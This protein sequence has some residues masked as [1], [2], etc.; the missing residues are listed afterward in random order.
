MP[1]SP[2]PYVK[3]NWYCT[4]IGGIQHQKLCPAEQGM[5]RAVECLAS[6]MA[7]R[8]QAR[9]SGMSLPSPGP[10]IASPMSEASS[11]IV[12]SVLDDF[13]EFKE[14]ENPGPT[15][16][17]YKE[18]LKPI[19]T[20]FGTRPIATISTSD[21]TKYKGWLRRD[22][23]WKRGKNSV[24]RKGVG[25]TTVNHHL[26]AAKMFFSWAY[27][28]SRRHKYG[29][30]MNVFEEIGYLTEIPRDRLITEEEFKH[31]LEN[32]TDGNVAGGREDYQDMLRVLRRT[33]MRPQE[34][35]YL[36]WGYIH[37]SEHRIVF[38]ANRVKTKNRREVVLLDEVIVL[39]RNRFERL[40]KDLG[41]KPPSSNYVFAL[42]GKGVDGQRK[43]GLSNDRQ[44]PGH[45]AQRFRRLLSRCAKLGLIETEKSGQK[46]VPYSTRHTRITE[47]F[48][49]GHDHAVVMFEAGHKNPQ[50]TERY[51]HLASSHVASKI[52][53]TENKNDSSEVPPS[54]SEK[55]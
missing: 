52:R 16:D 26:R 25:P 42:P 21:A 40:S 1:R 48:T 24:V 4:S 7:Q 8:Y 44:K 55:E 14:E 28:P 53:S 17:W 5:K 37:W 35:R 34:L 2:K 50:T 47:L 18:K 36:Q 43:A 31:L 20:Q 30:T 32:C 22:K 46:L 45:F 15:F 29:L 9:V 39:L 49:E 13:L 54:S 41:E 38:P 19:F 27:K 51:K 33:T 6:L 12:Q 10:G 11:P 23:P 3:N